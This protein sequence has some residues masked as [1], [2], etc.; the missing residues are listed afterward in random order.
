MNG[1]IE[2]HLLINLTNLIIKS[3]T[4]YWA[5]FLKKSW[6]KWQ[7]GQAGIKITITY[8]VMGGPF[9][10]KILARAKGGWQFLGLIFSGGFR[11]LEK[12]LPAAG[13]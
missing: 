8:C 4:T 3:S 9:I 2:L 12:I 7:I 13:C 1:K 6:P 5:I 11:F 10:L